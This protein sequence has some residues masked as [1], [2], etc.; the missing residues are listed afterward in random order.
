ATIAYTF[1]GGFLAVS[2][3]DTV[4]ASLMI[5]A[6]ILTPIVVILSLGGID[7]SIEVIKAKNPEYLDMFKGMNFVAILSLLGWGLGYFG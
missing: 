4:Q 5:F 6:L 3:T 2:W 7:T 1:L